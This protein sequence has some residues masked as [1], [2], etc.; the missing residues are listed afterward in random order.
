MRAYGADAQASTAPK[1]LGRLDEGH[2][3]TPLL[4]PTHAHLRVPKA[5]RPTGPGTPK[6]PLKAACR[7]CGANSPAGRPS[8]AAVP[9]RPHGGAA[10]RVD[11]VRHDAVAL[12]QALSAS[13]PTA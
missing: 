10:V 7:W 8:C 2:R 5:D 6:P 4:A 1:Q 9:V 13:P 11:G 3:R 12:T